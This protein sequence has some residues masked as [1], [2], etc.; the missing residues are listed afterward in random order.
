MTFELGSLVA[1]RSMRKVGRIT[2]ILGNHITIEVFYSVAKQELIPTKAEDLFLIKLQ[3]GTRC[4][5]RNGE[6]WSMGRTGNIDPNDGQL[7]FKGA[8]G[9][10][11]FP[12]QEIYV[13]TPGAREDPL[14]VMTLHISA[15]DVH[16]Y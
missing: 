15:T 3:S 13:R 1:I 10:G 9:W 8:D 6:N 12:P 5:R 2:Q 7:E 14:E 4:Y 16:A 11:Y